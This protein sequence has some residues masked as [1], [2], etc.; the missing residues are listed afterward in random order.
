MTSASCLKASRASNAEISVPK[1]STPAVSMP[2]CVDLDG[3]LLRT[4]SLHEAILSILRQRPVQ[5][6]RLVP[7]LLRGKAY[8]KQQATE[9]AAFDPKGL[10]LNVELVEYLR[11]QKQAGR[12]LALFSAAHATVVDAV[13]GGLGLFDRV[14]GSDETTNLAGAAKLAA[15]RA[16]YGED[17]AYA[18]N[19]RVDLPIWRAARAAVVVTDDERL[20]KDAAAVAAVEARFRPGGGGLRVWARALRLHQ[21][22]KNALLFV[23]LILAGPLTS[24]AEYVDGLLGFLVFGLL[25]SAGYLANDLLDLEADRRHRSKW[26]RPFAAGELSPASGIVMAAALVLAAVAIGAFLPAGFAVAACGYFIGTL[27]YSLRL[28]RI[29]LLDVLMLAGLFTIRILAGAMLTSSPL[30]FWLLTFSMFLFLSLALVKRYTELAE[31]ETDDTAVLASRGYGPQDL[32][33]I[34]PLG[35][36]S[37]LSAAL[38]FVIYL[39][40]ERFPAAIYRH[41]E[42]L[43]LVFPILLFWL[44]RVW[45]LAVHGRMHDDPVLFALRDPLSL[46]LGGAVGLLLLLAW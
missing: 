19:A 18:G 24:F 12:H 35:L 23:P 43:W 29:P 6:L 22:S 21:W 13:A 25:A 3:T 1:P 40:D 36:G 17:F 26:R 37:A 33:L 34:L 7:A 27:V 31:L 15:I 14:M 11:Q 28:K 20:A 4:D 9:I 38:I 46:A 44:M 8:F 5:L 42:W 45:R 10:P 30:S 16:Q 32:P 41:P 2:L 39:V